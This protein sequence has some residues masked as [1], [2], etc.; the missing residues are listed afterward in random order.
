MLI[1]SFRPARASEI[2]K[3]R[4]TARLLNHF[5]KD[6]ISGVSSNMHFRDFSF[7]CGYEAFFASSSAAFDIAIADWSPKKSLNFMAHRK[8]SHPL[9]HGCGLVHRAKKASG[10]GKNRTALMEFRGAV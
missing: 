7:V 6:I 10:C 2:F 1:Q 3:A 4:I 5:R 9:R 8:C